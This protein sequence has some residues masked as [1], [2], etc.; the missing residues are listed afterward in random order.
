MSIRRVAALRHGRRR[1]KWLWD[2][3]WVGVAIEKVAEADA[4]HLTRAARGGILVVW[5][6][7]DGGSGFDGG[8]VASTK[9]KRW[10][11]PLDT[12]GGKSTALRAQDWPCDSAKILDGAWPLES[13][14]EGHRWQWSRGVDVC[15]LWVFKDRTWAIMEGIQ[16]A[17]R[18]VHCF[19]DEDVV[20]LSSGCKVEVSSRS[21]VGAA[22][23]GWGS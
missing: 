4:S 1:A 23:M 9:R 15:V 19:L 3:L 2:G 16:A 14:G 6:R 22:M 17:N 12:V 21:R 5:L 18:R 11:R 13:W 8:T 7:S 20:G 10:K